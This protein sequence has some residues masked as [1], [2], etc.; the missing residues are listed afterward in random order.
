MKFAAALLLFLI[1]PL[2]AAQDAEAAFAGFHRA[3]LAGDAEGMMRYVPSAQRPE[4]ARLSPEQKSAQLQTMG[5][6]MPRSF[7]LRRKTMDANSQGANLIVSGPG[8]VLVGGKPVTMYGVIRMALE[9]GEWKVADVIW[10][11]EQPEVLQAESKVAPLPAAPQAAPK[12]EQTPARPSNAAPVVGS[13]DAAPARKLGTA[14]PP[15]EYKPVM[16]AEDLEN[17]K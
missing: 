4:L 14:K 8:K 6:L 15:C 9:G 17:C 3:I 5:A 12:F 7:L 11:N 16:T 13:M 1:S 10:S 2:A